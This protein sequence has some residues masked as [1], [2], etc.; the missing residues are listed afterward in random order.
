VQERHLQK[1]LLQSLFMQNFVADKV[2][3]SDQSLL[4]NVSGLAICT[5]WVLPAGWLAILSARR[6]GAKQ[7]FPSLGRREPV[8]LLAAQQPEAQTTCSSTD[9]LST[10]SSC[11]RSV[12]F[13][14]W[15]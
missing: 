10:E 8:F 2:L 13:V 5:C 6:P 4:Q 1:Q 9:Q 15:I 3:R 12:V 11:L 14:W 7:L